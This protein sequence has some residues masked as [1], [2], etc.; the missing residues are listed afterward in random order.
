MTAKAPPAPGDEIAPGS[1]WLVAGRWWGAALALLLVVLS[2]GP[3][4]RLEFDESIES[5]Y[6]PGDPRLQD[7]QRS[8]AWFGG[9]EFV[10][11][12]YTDDPL[13]DA[14]GFRREAGEK[15]RALAEQLA[16]V[17]G[18]RAGSVQHM[19]DAFRFR[20]APTRLRKF[21]EGVLLGADER[22]TAVACRLEAESHSPVPRAE[23]IRRIREI[24][25]NH[26]PPAV[27]VGEPIQVH[28]MFR[29]VEDDGATLGLASTAFLM[30]VILVMFRSVRW[31]VLPV[32]IVQ[33][34]L[35]WTK[36]LLVCSGVRLSMVSSMLNS[37]ATIIGIATVMHVTVR[38]RDRSLAGR[39]R[40]SATRETIGELA[41]PVFWTV[42]TTMAGFGSLLSSRIAP[43]NSF[44]LMMTIAT[45]FVLV[46]AALV[47][48][49]GM[50]CG[51]R[52]AVPIVT[53]LEAQMTAGLHAMARLV[54]RYPRLI[55]T[56]MFCVTGF[57]LLGLFRLELETDFSKNFRDSS[58]IVRGLNFFEHRLG[59]AGT[60]EV[61]FPAPKELDDAFLEEVRLLTE[62]LRTL[63]SRTTPDRLTKVIAITDGIDLIPSNL[64]LFRL[65]PQRRL[66]L[67]TDW[68]P[69]F[70][71]SL[72]S[73]QDG[74][75]RIM[76][77]ALE[78][79]PAQTKL[80]L[81]E[82]VRDLARKRF[83]EAQTTGLF[84][85]LANI[86]DSLMADQLTSSLW[87]GATII[88]LMWL[89]F[90]RF[91]LGLI[92]ILPNIVPVALVIGGMGWLGLR[93]NIATAMIASVS[94]GITVDSSIHYV[95]EYLRARRH[96]ADFAQAIDQVNS[97]AGLALVLANIALV[98]GFLVLTL[99]HF[100]PAV[101]FGVL[102]SAAMLGGLF[103]NLIMLPLLLRW[104]RL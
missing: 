56:L 32:I 51:R 54:A 99:S 43:V 85:L 20:F 84:V 22:T 5:L 31:M 17:P 63:E 36:A 80:R 29:Y 44:G 1:T 28:D 103:G 42:V 26:Q 3:A 92:L 93:V 46:A 6:A 64:I 81:I 88:V 7:F 55:G 91:W 82:E 96:G 62:D 53:P 40:L 11:V 65:T 21:L 24:A 10:I 60:W 78:R 35:L 48:P 16:N 38:F 34:A 102:V 71:T 101:Y 23:T 66:A 45:G 97:S 94:M 73:P 72:H 79:Q 50:L 104:C 59:G 87:S 30:F 67:V 25:T 89:A 33:L 47:V 18:I 61:N 75:M 90:R 37:L 76:L 19:A 52:T 8:K 9:D 15:I 39:D 2:W 49:A 95:S 69:E 86:I 74:R 14:V 12:A 58:P 100:I 68:Q 27:V 57:G 70:V 83:P 41:I 4:S 13:F 98:A 77:R